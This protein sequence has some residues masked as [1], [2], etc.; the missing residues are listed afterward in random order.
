MDL[1]ANWNELVEKAHLD[2]DDEELKEFGIFC[3]EIEWEEEFGVFDVDE[4]KFYYHEFL[5]QKRL[6]W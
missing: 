2:L 6:G 4:V 1:P 5:E 3:E